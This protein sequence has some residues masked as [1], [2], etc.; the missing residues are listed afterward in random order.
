MSVSETNRTPHT[1]QQQRRRLAGMERPGEQPATTQY[2]P[3]FCMCD[4]DLY[5]CVCVC[6]RFVFT[7]FG[8]GCYA[9]RLMAR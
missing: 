4:A 8:R 6:D 5:M 7:S 9:V 1:V 2:R 3:L